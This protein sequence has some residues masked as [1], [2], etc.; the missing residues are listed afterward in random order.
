MIG[1]EKGSRKL[2]G[3]AP[4]QIELDRAFTALNRREETHP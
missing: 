1:E 2:F 3:K 4:L